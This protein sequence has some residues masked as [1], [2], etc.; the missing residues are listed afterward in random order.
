MERKPDIARDAT[1]TAAATESAAAD[2]T[3]PQATASNVLGARDRQRYDIVAEHGR[4]GLGRVFRAH[5][6][7]L[8][9]D[10]ALKELLQRGHAG[11]LRFF[12]EALVTARLEHPGIVPVH[13]A[14]RW[15][16]GTPF[17]AMKLVGGRSLKQVIDDRPTL[18]D[19]LPLIANIIAVAD[20]MAYAHDR[21]II[22]RDLKPANV[23][24]GDFGETIVIDWGLAKALDDDS[25]DEDDL[26]YRSS[27]RNELTA[28]G[29][30]LGTPAYMA[31]EQF[32]G[33]VDERAD[34]YAL[35][36]MLYH[37]L[38]GQPPHDKSDARS[39]KPPPLASNVPEDLAAIVLRA[40][41]RDPDRRYPTARALAEDLGR[42]QRH[43]RVSARRYSLIARL[44]LA[45]ERH[46]A[47]AT[48]AM[49]AMV[50]LSVT[51]G[52]AAFKIARGRSEAVVAREQAQ[53]SNASALLD[54]DP[55]MAWEALRGVPAT[56]ETTL[57]RARIRAA[58]I[59]D[60]VVPLPARYV[61]V[62]TTT[63]GTSVVVA[64][65]DRALSV[66]EPDLGALKKLADGLTEPA[67]WETTGDQVYFVRSQPHLALAVVSI[68][69]GPITELAPL[70]A[71]PDNLDVAAERV[72]WTLDH[73]LYSASVVSAPKVVRREVEDFAV[74]EDEAAACHDGKLVDLASGVEMGTC[75][76]QGHAIY[77]RWGF[78][79]TAPG[80]LQVF[81]H[82]QKRIVDTTQMPDASFSRITSTGLLVGADRNE[83]LY[84]RAG[85]TEVEHVRFANPVYMTNAR[86]DLATWAFADGS[87][88]VRDT[89]RGEEWRIQA[90]SDSLW[91]NVVL[92]GHRLLTCTRREIRLW[93]LPATGAT[94]RATIPAAA[95][96]LVFDANHTA[97]LDGNNGTGYVIT[98]GTTTATAVHRHDN[99]AYGAAWC[100]GEACT[101]G[102]DGTV[103]CTDVARHTSRVAAKLDANTAWLAEGSGH[104]FTV[105]TTGGVYDLRAPASPLYRHAH[106]PTRVAV[107]RDSSRVA[108]VDWAGDVKVY[109]VARRAVIAEAT[110]HHGKI[111]DVGWADDQVVTAGEDGRVVVSSAA[112]VPLHEW[113]LGAAVRFLVVAGEH[114][115]IGLDDGTLLLASTRHGVLHKVTTRDTF[116][117]VA[118][119]PD[120]STVAAGTAAGDLLIL[121]ADG[122]AAAARF[123]R[124]R[125]SCL[126][127]EDA[128]AITACAP[129]GRIMRIPLSALSFEPDLE[130]KNPVPGSHR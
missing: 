56:D 53:I 77:S 102:Q 105:T 111:T 130:D 41:D 124:G 21:R 45:F 110:V 37:V 40:M 75:S 25:P 12:R 88:E 109:D 10:V 99:A 32:G 120:G 18:A 33:Q 11:E 92:S 96:N 19:R 39:A 51:L 13:E 106:E 126:A 91:C 26:P 27:A 69:G 83:G 8:G 127:F 72:W 62:A 48:V 46:R 81:Q 23:M 104:C 58:G 84:Q 103:M 100:D 112:L 5:D 17:Y 64:T 86:G 52:V 70:T 108:S 20:A 114:A 3:A 34:I 15:S 121:A 54:R 116:G 85:A 14:G 113:Q 47:V 57:L 93:T 65:A 2:A 79:Y 42:Y 118:I 59:A 22:H 66:L 67:L 16:D 98:A 80:Q 1:W 76:S 61:G 9:R 28:A 6:R 71:V 78:G 89:V 119:S 94:L 74:A 82:G 29:S 63:D 128:T 43:D 73:T 30:S 129:S 122:R 7:E 115:A 50:V 31:P 87:V 55:T 123:G 36:G 38:A 68:K 24:V 49:L 125:I 4:G 90:S 97:I 107:S 35:G 117:S 95:H 44:G 101:S 60:Q